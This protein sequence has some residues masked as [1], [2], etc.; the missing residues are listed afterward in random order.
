[1]KKN[2]ELNEGEIKAA[3][4]LYLKIEHKFDA[5]PKSV[6]IHKSEADR[7]FDSTYLTGGASGEDIKEKSLSASNADR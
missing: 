4:V 5:D 2:I 1:M 6:F 3:I 7:P